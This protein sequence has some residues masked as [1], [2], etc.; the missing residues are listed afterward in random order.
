MAS[1]TQLSLLRI[2]EKSILL[3]AFLSLYITAVS[4]SC[5]APNGTVMLAE[6]QP[7]NNVG[8]S[9]SMCCATNRTSD[10]DMCQ[11][12]GLCYNPNGDY[13]WREGCTDPTWT[14]E[15]CSLLCRSG[16]VNPNDPSIGDYSMGSAPLTICDDESICC[17]YQNF[18]DCCNKNLGTRINANGQPISGSSSSISYSTTT[19]ANGQPTSSSS[20]S[21]SHGTITSSPGS[22]S[23][24]TPLRSQSSSEGLSTGAKVGIGIGIPAA[25]LLGAVAGFFILQRRRGDRSSGLG[26]RGSEG[27][28][29]SGSEH[30][31]Q[32][33][34]TSEVSGDHVF[35]NSSAAYPQ[36]LGIN[37]FPIGGVQAQGQGHPRLVQSYSV[38][39]R[40]E[41][42]GDCARP[43]ELE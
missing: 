36:G 43:G 22:T 31:P 9:Y 20:S 8:G 21:I 2:F 29:P 5:Y 15:A 40:N 28:I 34:G 1:S 23:P 39:P 37:R 25:L 12:D 4:A 32:V 41:L 26:G 35:L 42:L 10:A 30:Y 14:S 24:Q 27:V 17:G 18:T 19:N 13:Y 6:N 7:C 33:T 3:G 16:P 11:Q 38:H